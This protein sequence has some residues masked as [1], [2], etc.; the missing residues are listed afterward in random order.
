MAGKRKTGMTDIYG[1][2]F[3]AEQ[4]AVITVIKDR[5]EFRAVLY[6]PLKE[7]K[8][9]WD[10]YEALEKA[11]ANRGYKI[12]P[13]NFFQMFLS[14]GFCFHDKTGHAAFVGPN[15]QDQIKVECGHSVGV[16]ETDQVVDIAIFDYDTLEIKPAAATVWVG[17]RNSKHR[18]Q[19]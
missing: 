18:A 2:L 4:P 5:K 1:E 8:G 6:I 7:G 12:P 9:E 17:I 10:P 19:D 16:D 14:C 15:A 3:D 11:F 13:Q